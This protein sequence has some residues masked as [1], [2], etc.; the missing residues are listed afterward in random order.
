[1]LLY[2]NCGIIICIYIFLIYSIFSD[3]LFI[4]RASLY[5]SI[6][7]LLK[8]IFNYRKCTFGYWECKL[9][10]VKRKRGIINNFCEYYGD[11]IYC[12]YNIYLFIILMSVYTIQLIKFIKSTYNYI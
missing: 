9:R 3:D 12:D 5:L 1:M 8:W 4:I 6:F 7:M 2:I 11:L 10:N